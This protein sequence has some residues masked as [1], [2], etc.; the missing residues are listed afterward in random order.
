LLKVVY[1]TFDTKVSSS[2]LPKKIFAI[3]CQCGC[4]DKILIMKK[5][6][7]CTL[8][9]LLTVSASLAQT[10]KRLTERLDSVLIATQKSDFDGIL[11]FTYPKLFT[12][13]TR[14]Q[15]LTALKGALDAD[16]FTTTIDSVKL[17]KV[18]PVFT[19]GK[20]SYAKIEHT[21]LTLMKFKEPLD[22]ADAEGGGFMLKMMAEQF[23]EQ[24]V[25]FDKATNTIRLFMVADM[26]AIKDE[27]AKEWCFVNYDPE[28]QLTTLLFSE[29]VIEKLIEY[30]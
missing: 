22:T 7:T 10:D 28:S 9:Y 24:N 26:V 27:Y 16:E 12:I 23:G 25:R 2:G 30:K 4:F 20:G 3:P 8:F 5:I 29:E 14:P 6:F 18:Y 1:A 13:V 19:I 21:M 17:K 15:M 11:D